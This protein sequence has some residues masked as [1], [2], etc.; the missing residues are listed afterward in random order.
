MKAP[1]TSLHARAYCHA[2]EVRE[3][4]E[5]AVANA[6]GEVEL[7]TS[8]TQGHHGNEILV[9]ET[10]AKGG[11][12]AEL[13]LGKLSPS[14]LKELIDTIDN[15]IDESCNL[16]M[17]IDKQKA[18]D[19]EIALTRGGDAIA[20]RIKVAAYPAKKEAAAA[21]AKDFLLARTH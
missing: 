17:R 12:Q 13:L 16:F 18:F 1:F 14:D 5:Q 8:Q 9:I 6:M 21:R 20:V 11:Q 2:T 15:R 4:V 19:G 3:R 7:V 10:H